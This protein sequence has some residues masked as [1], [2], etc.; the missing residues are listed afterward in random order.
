MPPGLKCAAALWALLNAAPLWASE[1]PFGRT[2]TGE[3]GDVL[4]LALPVSA[5]VAAIAHRDWEGARQYS[6]GAVSVLAVTYALKDAVERERPDGRS[7]NSFPSGHTAV[8]THAAAHLRRRYGLKWGIPAYL[9]ATY[10]GYSR[11]YDD[12]HYEDDVLVG[13][14]LGMLSAELFTRE[15]RG[16]RFMADVR[17]GFFGLLA[18]MHL[19]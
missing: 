9:A 17:P 18:R 1:N 15:Y 4:E 5:A 6:M 10:V 13:A 14:A 2:S 12:R 16:V 11:V 19:P 7:N 3:A 8:A